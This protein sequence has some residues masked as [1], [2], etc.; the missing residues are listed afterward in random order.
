M[1]I[2]NPDYDPEQFNAR[3]SSAADRILL[4]DYDG[5]IAPFNEERMKAF[6]YPGT[7]RLIS[8]II[9]SGRCRVVIISGRP[10]EDLSKL[11]QLDPMPE[12]WG[13][14]GWERLLPG[15][16]HL[17]RSPGPDVDSFLGKASEW[18]IE[19]GLEGRFERK[20]VSIA[21]HWRG[22]EP[23]LD[24]RIC[25]MV[26]SSLLGEAAGAGMEM[27]RFSGGVELIMSEVS[28]G[29]AVDSILG[30]YGDGAAVA[31]L[32]DDDTD[33]YAF[34]ALGER[35]LSVLVSEEL[36]ETSADIWIR[37]PG[38]LISFLED[39]AEACVVV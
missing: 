11:V 25:G 10:I 17:V 9:A 14:H 1:K 34:R 16:K 8:S 12:M 35:G 21:F 27:R 24:E 26:R 3:L 38:E 18:A 23:G 30:E 31:Y 19:N 32:G 13:S 28:K 33:E 29:R 39:W 20:P 5:T 22:A 36:R 2:L 37:P 15:E 7:V 4:I 6:P